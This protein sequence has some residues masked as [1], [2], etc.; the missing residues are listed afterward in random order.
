MKNL[1]SNLIKFQMAVPVIPKNKIN[2][3]FSKGDNKSMYADLATVIDTCKPVLN[4]HGLAVMQ[5]MFVQDGRNCL[6]TILAD[7]SGETMA[8]DLFLPDIQDPQKL[9]AAVTYLRRCQYLAII[10]LVAD[11]DDDGNSVGNQEPRQEPQKHSGGQDFMASPKQIKFIKELCQRKQ[12]EPK[13]PVDKMSA[14]DASAFITWLNTQPD[15]K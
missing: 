14:A 8:S 11:E 13:K 6:R 1:V 4:K 9:T 12:Y 15:A 7:I 5:T 10:G 2:T 3:F